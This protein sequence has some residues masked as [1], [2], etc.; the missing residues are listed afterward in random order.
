VLEDQDT[1]V[2]LN[3]RL[4]QCKMGYKNLPCGCLMQ[5][6]EKETM[7]VFC[8]GHYTQYTDWQGTDI[9][10]VKIIATP[11]SAKGDRRALLEMQ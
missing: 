6:D 4:L 2:K 3:G 5:W 9:D 1:T 8:N 7:L 10:F 11:K